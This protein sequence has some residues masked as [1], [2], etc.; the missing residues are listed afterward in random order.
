MLG[1]LVQEVVVHQVDLQLVLQLQ[2]ELVL[3]EHPKLLEL[4]V[5]L[6][7]DLREIWHIPK[8]LVLLHLQTFFQPHSS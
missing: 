6:Q 7:D 5:E 8:Q 4:H 2:E 1:L 3:V